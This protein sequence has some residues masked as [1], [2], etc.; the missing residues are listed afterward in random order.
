[1]FL[2][3]T[4]LQLELSALVLSILNTANIR[5]VRASSSESSRPDGRELFLLVYIAWSLGGNLESRISIEWLHAF[6]R[7]M[8]CETTWEKL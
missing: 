4:L 2:F 3:Y 8:S 1:M 7:L 6:F 5:N